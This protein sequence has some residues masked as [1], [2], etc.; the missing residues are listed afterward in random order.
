MKII[1][2]L[3]FSFMLYS[4]TFSQDMDGM[5]MSKKE[6]K[7]KAQTTTYT[8]VMHPEIHADKPGNCPKCGMKLIKEKPK[9]IEKPTINKPIVNRHVEMQMPV[10]DTSTQKTQETK[11]IKTI[12]NITPPKTIRYDLYVGDTTVNFTGKNA[13]AMAING[14]IPAPTLHFTEGDTALIYVHNRLKIPTSVHWHGLIVPN[15]Y[16]GVSYL[17]TAPILPNTTHIFTFPLAQNGTYWYHSHDLE[18]QIG[19]YGAIVITPRPPNGEKVTPP[20]GV[21]G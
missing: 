19:L 17:T 13:A 18:E 3:A 4:S 1:I 11:P 8:C 6:T 20:L 7:K 15:Q 10:V 12:A 21:G 16:D 2:L 5:D 14:Q 9:K